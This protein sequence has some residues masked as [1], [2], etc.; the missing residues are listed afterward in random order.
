MGF[1]AR[2]FER[3]LIMNIVIKK[4]TPDLTVDY[5]DFFDNRAFTDNRE[6]SACYCV[7]YHWN[8]EYQKSAKKPGVNIHEHNRN[9]AADFI[10]NGIL[11]GY[12]AY[13]DGVVMG[14]VNANDKSAYE[15]LDSKKKPDLW[16][17]EKDRK[18]KSIT[19][20]TIAP[21]MRRKGIATKLLG[22]VCED[23]ASDGY[24]YVEA[25]PQKNIDNTQRN[26]NGP[27]ALYEKSGFVLHREL[28]KEFIVRK[29]L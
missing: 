12:L 21:E 4:L 17:D 24:D 6:W 14:W 3:K 7:F 22:R 1:A 28:E 19:C 29:Y 9:L 13:V 15:R 8:D 20:Y 10:R 2:I 23:A 27:M 16:D 5:L 26:Y 11:K 18:I 25:Y